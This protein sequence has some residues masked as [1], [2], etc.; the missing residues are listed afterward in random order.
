MGTVRLW[1]Q[2][3]HLPEQDGHVERMA[4]ARQYPESARQ[5]EGDADSHQHGDARS[6]RVVAIPAHLLARQGP[7]AGLKKHEGFSLLHI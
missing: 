5:N 3:D 2:A 4:A 6:I 7:G 1:P